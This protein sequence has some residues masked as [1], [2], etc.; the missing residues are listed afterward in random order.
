MEDAQKLIEKGRRKMAQIVED[1]KNIGIDSADD[2]TDILEQILAK[3]DDF[4]VN[5]YRFIRQDAIDDIQR[6]ELSSAP[7]ILGCF[8]AEFLAGITD[9]DVDAIKAIQDAGAFEALGKLALPHIDDIQRQYSSLDGYGN[10]FAH[11]DGEEHAIGDY[12]VF[13]TN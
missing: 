1:I 8:N 10:H 13:R 6:D 5:N 2:I 7:Y 9:I 3:E 4:E 11:Y 12:Y